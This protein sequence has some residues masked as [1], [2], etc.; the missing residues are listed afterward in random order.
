MFVK[1]PSMRDGQEIVG[2]RKSGNS[3]YHVYNRIKYY[4]SVNVDHIVHIS[5]KRWDKDFK[6][7]VLLSNDKHIDSTLSQDELVFQ[8]DLQ[9]T[10]LGK[11]L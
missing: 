10:K 11:L 4:I 7:Y 6:S 3:T 8:I 2:K 5:D 9:K 1:I